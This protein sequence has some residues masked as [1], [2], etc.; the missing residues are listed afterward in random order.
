MSATSAGRPCPTLRT[1]R[2]IL[3]GHTAADHGDSLSLWS[4][5]EVTRYVGGVPSTAEEVWSR[6]LRYG[7]LWSLLGHGFWHV[8]E[9]STGRFLGEAG[10]ADFRRA[11]DGVGEFAPETGWAFVPSA[12]GQGFAREAM[13]AVLDW[14]DDTLRARRTVCM[15]A[16]QNA[17]SL[18][19]AQRLGYREFTRAPYRGNESV[20]LERRSPGA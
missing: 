5:P 4:D 3:R 15:I 2:L 12:Q 17:P 8:S 16:P 1:Q 6:I 11:L 20:L 13:E 10:V 19:L 18:R 9:T 14:A 7:G